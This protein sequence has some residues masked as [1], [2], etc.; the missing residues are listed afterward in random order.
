MDVSPMRSAPTRRAVAELDP[1]VTRKRLRGRTSSSTG[2]V[3]RN[4]TVPR[5]AV[6]MARINPTCQEISGLFC[7]LIELGRETDQRVEPARCVEVDEI[8]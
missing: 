4:A 1:S 5:I 6:A 2:S 3:R 8:R 7:S